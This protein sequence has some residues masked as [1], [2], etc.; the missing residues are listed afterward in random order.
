M[1][2]EKR[3]NKR[4]HKIVT[5][6]ILIIGISILSYLNIDTLSKINKE[7]NKNKSN[8]SLLS[9]KNT[10]IKELESNNQKLN[11]EIEEIKNIDSKFV[12]L[13][14]EYFSNIK[15]LED[16]IIAGKSDKKIAYLTFDD[17][18]YY[19]TYK[20]LDILE[21]YNVNATFFN[22]GAGKESCYDNSKEDCTK[23]YKLIAS[24]DH[25]IGNHTYSHAIFYGLYSSANTFVND[26]LKQEKLVK[27]KA[28]VTT[29][30]YR[31]PGG[32]AT[33]GALK[34]SIVKQLRSK[35]YGYVD[36]T[37][38]DGD[39]G[40][41]NSQEEARINFKNSINEKI[42]VVLMHDY[43]T[44]TYSLLPEFIEYLQNKGYI[45]LPLF[46]ESNMVNK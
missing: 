21:K 9:E 10:N 2:K 3:N 35:G 19:L 29:N 6:I 25:T 20:Y 12:D 46:Y 11:Q 8:D 23:L 1:E 13:K 43:N 38:Q 22:M 31:F 39:G 34:E 18:P 27:E 16:L 26:V 4:I 41:L 40:D 44:I 42:E 45:L 30:I 15:K 33:A 14:K 17:G 32:S 37:A 24:K 28:G 5:I 7:K 36:W